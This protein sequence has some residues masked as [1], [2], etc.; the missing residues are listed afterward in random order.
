VPDRYSV[1]IN[2][3]FSYFYSR[4]T[5]N[6][7]APT[8]YWAQ[9][10]YGQLSIFPFRGFEI[11]TNASYTWQQKTGSFGSATS[12]LLWNGFVSQN[13][14]Q[15]QLTMRVSINNILDRNAGISRSNI[16][17]TNS[18]T[19]TNIM[20]RYW[21]LSGIWHFTHKRREH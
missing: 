19:T 12:V 5:I 14:L 16:G 9:S 13:F 6:I 17:N 3:N 15:N 20:G 8:H 10:H 1:S 7:S 18:E 11:N 21:M 2:T 4:S